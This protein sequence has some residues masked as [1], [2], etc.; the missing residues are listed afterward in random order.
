MNPKISVIMPSLDVGE[1]IRQCMESV[2][3]QSLEE[4]EIICIDAG[5]TDGTLEILEE[6]AAKDSRITLMHSDK[7]SYGYQMNQAIDAARG[8]YIAIVETDDYIS[9]DMLK[10]LYGLS[11]GSADVVKS[12]FYHV[13]E[14]GTI[15]KDT[16]KSGLIEEGKA[17]T[18]EDFPAIIK[19]HPSIWAGIYRLDFLKANGIRFIEEP[20]GGWVDNPFFYE[21]S[22]AAE[23]IV[24]TDEAYYYYREFNPTS[25]SNNLTDYT[26]P[27]K[28]ML[29]NLDVVDKY[30][31]KSE[32][33]L[34]AVY[35]RAMA[36]LRNIKKREYFEENLPEIRPLL[37]EMMLRIDKDYAERNFSLKNRIEYYRYL[38]PLM[39]DGNLDE[40]IIK[41]NDFLYQTIDELRAENEELKNENRKLTGDEKQP[42]IKSKLK[43]IF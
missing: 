24:Y 3:S 23:S 8:E 16:G 21:T 29:D 26:I 15:R 41:E 12:S 28:R 35:I 27:I 39:L 31:K 40:N 7:K 4:I 18:I 10:S 9:K 25:S 11:K 42:S 13:T 34:R 1:Y 5:S 20:G 36:Y 32:E 6:F 43:R 33:I 2:T 14:D 17:F 38:S 37:H 22:F 19:S 30:D